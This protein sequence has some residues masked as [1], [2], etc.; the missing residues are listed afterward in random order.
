[1]SSVQNIINILNEQL[2]NPF[3]L[4]LA[5]ILR[6]DKSVHESEFKSLY[7][8][9]K[10][11]VKEIE[12]KNCHLLTLKNYIDLM[13]QKPFEEINVLFKQFF[14]T[15][16]LIWSYSEYYKRPK[17]FSILMQ[18]TFNLML[19]KSVYYL[20]PQEL[21]KQNIEE[22]RRKF[23]TICSFSKVLLEV[24][25]QFGKNLDAVFL[26]DDEVREME[27]PKNF[28]VDRWEKF[29]HRIEMVKVFFPSL[30][31]RLKNCF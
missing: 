14:H 19:Q 31:R 2:Y 11:A 30:F 9:F 23:D 26:K 7:S 8:S 28:T 12:D 10:S 17:N 1:L 22:I 6:D 27:L 3:I 5:R 20:K 24:Y 21:L 25:G 4:Q 15:L 18:Q 29:M 13:D 16:S